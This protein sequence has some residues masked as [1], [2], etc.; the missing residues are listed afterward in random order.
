MVNETENLGI[1]EDELF[2]RFDENIKRF[3]SAYP[4]RVKEFLKDRIESRNSILEFGLKDF[5]LTT[6]AYWQGYR[7]SLGS[8]RLIVDPDE[9]KTMAENDIL[10]AESYRRIVTEFIAPGETPIDFNIEPSWTVIDRQPE[11]AL[12]VGVYILKDGAGHPHETIWDLRQ[13]E[14]PRLQIPA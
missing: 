14:I 13:K 2:E 12:G 3:R 8:G 1:P 11:R 9:S 6:D 10:F 7:R 5:P 4:D